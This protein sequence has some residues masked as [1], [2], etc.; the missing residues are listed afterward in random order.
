MLSEKSK[1]II[2]SLLPHYQ[3]KQSAMIPALYLAQKE[4]GHLTEEAIR[5]VAAVLEV[6]PTEVWGVSGFYSLLYD[7]PVG[8]YVLHI[9][10]DLPCAL[11][12]AEK[13][14]D[15]V[16]RKLGVKSGQTTPDGMFTLERVM[17]L[18]A[19]DKAPVMQVNL[20]F[21]ENMTPEQ[22]DRLIDD[23]RSGKATA[24]S[25]SALDPILDGRDG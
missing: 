10:D 24:P 5:E 18:G 17:C 16:C 25:I 15:H 11:R 22:A 21:Y 14:A 3:T 1:G 9:C 4:Y 6:D 12:G 19:C 23:L 13:F 20:E 8:R 7:A 2:Q